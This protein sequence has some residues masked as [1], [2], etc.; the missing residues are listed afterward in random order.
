MKPWPNVLVWTAD[1]PVDALFSEAE[2]AQARQFKLPKRRDEWLLARAAAKQLALDLGITDDPRTLAIERPQTAGWYV[3]LS[4]SG[5]YA[6]AAF[7]RHP[8]G[9]DVQVI[10]EI[11]EWSTHLFLSDGEAAEMRDCKIDQRVL[12]FWCAKEAAF[13]RAPDYVT[14]K[15]TPLRLL[16]E[17]ENG[18]LFDGA[19]TIRIDDFI[20]AITRPTS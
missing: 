18:L 9:L 1:A 13:K 2:L 3:S 14:M 16:E 5:A 12:H 19:E 4:H 17:R 20:V 8:I 15:Q 6:G 10:R 7:A 11:A